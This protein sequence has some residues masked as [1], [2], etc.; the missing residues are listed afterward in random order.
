MQMVDS[1]CQECT[2]CVWAKIS[3]SALRR[4]EALRR[5]R[6]QALDECDDELGAVE[7]ERGAERR[8]ALVGQP[9][10]QAEQRETA[11]RRAG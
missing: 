7:E 6:K 1:C 8:G 2:E 4:C 11:E 9:S 5:R 10:R 3:A